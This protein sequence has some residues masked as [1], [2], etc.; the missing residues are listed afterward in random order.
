MASEQEKVE[1]PADEPDFDR[2]ALESATAAKMADVFKD[3]DT[4]LENLDAVPD[5]DAEVASPAAR[6]KA[7][8]QD[9]S[10]PEPKTIEEKP[11][12][13][14]E[15]TPVSEQAG[16]PTPAPADAST[17][18]AA[19]TRSLKAA[20]WTDGEIKAGVETNPD[21][22]LVMAE[23][24]H[25]SRNDETRRWAALGQEQKRTQTQAQSSAAPAVQ[26]PAALQ[27]IDIEA[28]KKKYGD[29]P[30][31]AELAKANAVIQSA[32]QMQQ[33]IAKSQERQSRSEMETIGRQVEAF[34]GSD[35]LKPYS[36]LYGGSPATMTAEQ[37]TARVKLL[38]T[39]DLISQG[40]RALNRSLS[41][42]EILQR[43]HEAVSGP[44]KTKAAASAL[45]KQVQQRQ[46][47]LSLRPNSRV[48]PP[49]NSTKAK[50]QALENQVKEGLA[51]TFK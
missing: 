26:P 39:A 29:E 16:K 25:A 8:A 42:D 22:F 48:A 15:D 2:G 50:R 14:A 28:L 12:V 43:A 46:K 20:G 27:Q 45:V 49:A 6:H 47:S 38:D 9:D 19:Y 33:W 30:F 44:V 18:P 5:R 51:K 31:V 37:H 10:E 32:Q 41:L 1:I 36:D 11:N 21:K 34:F 40:A 4:T 3:G 13:E 7:A 24:I 35:E 17:L 23:R